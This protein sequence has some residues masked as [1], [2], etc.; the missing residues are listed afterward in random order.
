[1][2]DSNGTIVDDAG[3]SG[4]KWDFLM[5]LKNNRSGRIKEYADK[6]KVKYYEGKSVWDVVRENNLRLI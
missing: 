5:D 6:Y 1:M 3:I 2:S 4:D